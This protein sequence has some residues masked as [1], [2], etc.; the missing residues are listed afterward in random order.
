MDFGVCLSLWF[1]SRS[2]FGGRS[3]AEVQFTMPR[4]AA[5]GFYCA[6][7]WMVFACGWCLAPWFLL[8]PPT[9]QAP[10]LVRLAFSLFVIGAA[11][12]ALKLVWPSNQ[13]IG[14]LRG[15][16]GESVFARQWHVLAWEVAVTATGVAVLELA[17]CRY[18]ARSIGQSLLVSLAVIVVLA[19]VYRSVSRTFEVV[20]SRILSTRTEDEVDGIDSTESPLVRAQS[21]LRLLF[22][23]VGAVTLLG[24]WGLDMCALVGLDQLQ[25][26]SL[27]VT[28]VEPVF[29]TAGDLVRAILFLLFR[30]G[31]FAVV[32]AGAAWCVRS[33]VRMR[34]LSA[35]C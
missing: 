17:G 4:A 8:Q 24:I 20:Y 34:A 3:I 29:V 7:R 33:G 22:L 10:S 35:R 28:G 32:G 18:A 6:F 16:L 14:Y 31:C 13:F 30:C 15:R 25:I 2:F 26:Y 1:A 27:R 9:F 23:S 19:F 5:N 21:F 12:G 11:A